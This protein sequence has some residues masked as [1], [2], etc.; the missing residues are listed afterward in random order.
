M[1]WHLVLSVSLLLLILTT[2]SLIGARSSCELNGS[3]SLGDALNGHEDGKTWA[4]LVA[5]SNE[6]YN[7]RHQADVCHA[8]QILKRGGLKDENIVVFMYDDIANNEENP[9]PGV[10]I[11][12]PKGH[13]VYAGVPKD[14]TGV[15]VTASNFYAVLLGDKKSVKGGSRKVVA[16]KPNDRIFV[17]YSDHGGPGTLGMPNMPNVY[18]KDFIEVLEKKYASGTYKE[19]ESSWGTYCP[20]MEPPPPPEYDTC[21]GDLYSVAWMEDSEKQ[22]SNGETLEEQYRTVKVRTF[23]HNSSEGSHVMEYGTK[24]INA[25]SISL[26]QG[27]GATNVS[28]TTPVTDEPMGVVNQRDADLVF[29]QRKYEKLTDGSQEKADM[30]KKITDIKNH[31]SHL[32][33]SIDAIGTK[34]FGRRNSRVILTS[35]RGQG[36]PIVDDWGCLKSMVRV[37]ETHCGSLT[38][39]GM[40]HMR[41]LANICN[42]KVSEADMTS[43]AVDVCG[44]HDVGQWN[45]L[46]KGYSA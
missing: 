2:P 16:S 1:S 41:A 34:L 32:D 11:N 35:L 5:G 8:Y 37:Y 45:P 13:D 28:D 18:A 36:K 26:Y 33:S 44:T 42:N 6:Y 31:R 22:T 29:Y 40:K 46:K 3:C 21:L 10:I 4:V 14:Y 23:N 30:L 20:G 12:S 7:Y 19:M 38:E 27:F 39:Y 25:E 9:K 24:D 15:S 43:A 17:Y